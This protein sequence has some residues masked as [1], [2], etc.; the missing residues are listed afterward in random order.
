MRVTKTIH[1]SLV[2]F[3][4][5]HLACL[6]ALP[7]TGRSADAQESG[8]VS[9]AGT[10][11]QIGTAWGKLNKEL[12]LGDLESSYLNKADKA[13][14]SR[15]A[16]LERSA[17][18]IR[19]AKEIAP[20][21]LEEARATARAIGVD[22][23]LYQAFSDGHSRNRFLHEC[24]SYAVSREHTKDGAIF[25]HKT[26]DNTDRPQVACVVQSSLK[27]INKFIT[28]SDI[29]NIRCSM[30]VNDKGLAGSAD[31]PADKKKD[32]STLVLPAAAP[33]YRGLMAGSILRH[34]AERASTC[35]E[36]LAI[37]EDFV[38][39]GYY[40]GGDVNGSHWLFVDRTG[41]ILE[42]CNNSEH[43]VSQYHTEKVY[44]SRL[45]KSAAAKQLET[46]KAPIDFP[47]FHSV[48]RDSSVCFGS[49]ISGMTVEID[50]THPELFT[51]AWVAL[52][53][54]S[55]AFPLLMGQDATPSPLVDGSA[56]Q[57]G[58]SK[59]KTGAPWEKLERSAHAEMEDIKKDGIASLSAGNPE[60][61]QRE[62]MNQWSARQ[63]STL[64]HSIKEVAAGA[65]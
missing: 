11:E 49:S 9:L 36:A 61:A 32:S 27:G 41:A 20:H 23:D 16:L 24:T 1:S 58:K 56:Y 35:A 53:A 5:L 44:F 18:S 42:V 62:L 40:A 57:K 45:R 30:V 4:V 6:L 47:T 59:L 33:R 21:W 19:I 43:V 37:I 14:I 22:E 55:V 51:C 60:E 31:Y 65:E 50:P 26:R 28:V 39:K 8:M 46:T 2:V 25:F 34:I 64:Y 52:P 54:H 7:L 13:G 15:E 10:P 48:A 29:G 3:R 38:K 63:A 17:A 12:I